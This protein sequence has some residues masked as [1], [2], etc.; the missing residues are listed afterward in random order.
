MGSAPQRGTTQNFWVL[1]FCHDRLDSIWRRN[2]FRMGSAPQR[3]TTQNLATFMRFF[4]KMSRF[5][6]FFVKYR[7]LCNFLA[8]CRDLRT[9]SSVPPKQSKLLSVP[10]LSFYQPCLHSTLSAMPGLANNTPRDARNSSR[11]LPSWR[12]HITL[13]YLW[14]M[15]LLPIHISG[16]YALREEDGAWGRGRHFWWL[17]NGRGVVQRPRKLRSNGAGGLSI[18]Y[19]VVLCWIVE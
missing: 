16:V 6:R 14:Y 19:R 15:K 5:T 2:P 4:G 18:T 11:L 3:G 1:L 10:P 13:I 12:Y 9:F 17:T 7:H 8:K